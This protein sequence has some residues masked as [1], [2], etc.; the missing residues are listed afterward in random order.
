VNSEKLK[1]IIRHDE[2]EVEFEGDYESV[3][4]SVNKFFSE[5]YPA[6]EIVKKLTGAIDVA[7]LA[8][9]LEGLVEFREGRI[10]ILKEMDAKRKILLCLAA[11]NVGKALGL[12]EKDKL[13]PKEIAAYTGLDER[14]TRARLSE[15][16]RAGLVIKSGEGLYGFTSSSLEE[17]FGERR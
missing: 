6:L 12:F 17:V 14:V 4:R 7:D 3:W 15:L 10:I 11:A 13:A 9:R 2:T 5:T 16:R 1:V 8:K